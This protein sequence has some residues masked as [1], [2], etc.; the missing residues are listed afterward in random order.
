MCRN[1]AKFAGVLSAL[2]RH[3]SSRKTMSMTQCRLLFKKLIEGT[4]YVNTLNQSCLVHL[5]LQLHIASL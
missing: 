4:V 1:V 2:T 3:S 5:T